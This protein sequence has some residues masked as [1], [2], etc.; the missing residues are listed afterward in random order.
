MSL[1]VARVFITILLFSIS[2]GV[3]TSFE[4]SSD[5]VTVIHLDGVINFAASELIREGMDE[6]HKI[7]AKA[8]VLLLNTPGGL[9]DATFNIL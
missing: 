6:A 5:L 9:L 2:L 1:R 4:P 7:N 8:V 3:C